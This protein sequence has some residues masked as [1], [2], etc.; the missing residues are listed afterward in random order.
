MEVARY[1]VQLWTLLL[2][3]VL[4]RSR[5]GRNCVS[6][7]QFHLRFSSFPI[8]FNCCSLECICCY[9]LRLLQW[10]GKNILHEHYAFPRFSS[11]H[12]ER[13]RSK[14]HRISNCQSA[15]KLTTRYMIVKQEPSTRQHPPR[16]NITLSKN[17]L[18]RWTLTKIYYS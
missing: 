16:K 14:T 3:M 12:A 9:E 17:Y 1:V 7:R 2:M 11:W 6:E 4:F 8:Y 13:W 15:L 18:S 5:I 10:V